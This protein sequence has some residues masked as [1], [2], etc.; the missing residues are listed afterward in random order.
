M[1]LGEI[2]YRVCRVAGLKK[3][4]EI[5]EKIRLLPIRIVSIS[6]AVVMEAAKIKGKYPISYAD[7]F[8]V[9]VALQTGATVVS[10]DPEYNVVSKLIKILWIK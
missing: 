8:A 4:E 3:A 6:D 10:G 9:A 2:F 5:I 7:A 1:N